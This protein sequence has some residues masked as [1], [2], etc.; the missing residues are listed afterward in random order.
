MNLPNT[1]AYIRL[2]NLCVVLY[3][4]AILGILT[5]KFLLGNNSVNPRVT[6]TLK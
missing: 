4:I 5:V 6:M 3:V 2:A 1:T